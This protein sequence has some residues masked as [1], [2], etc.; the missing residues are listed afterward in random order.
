MP[1]W[2]LEHNRRCETR[3]LIYRWT[4][5]AIWVAVYIMC[6]LAPASYVQG[7]LPRRIRKTSTS[8]RKQR[9]WKAGQWTCS[10]PPITAVGGFLHA[11]PDVC[12][13][14]SPRLLLIIFTAAS[15]T[16]CLVWS[17]QPCP[18]AAVS[19]HGDHAEDHTRRSMPKER[20][21]E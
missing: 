11:L 15:R 16:V 10:S 5:D 7:L 1:L 14:L 9:D 18:H 17:S 8:G 20:R 4:R 21:G 19:R 6:I 13:H 12:F 3:L 2:W